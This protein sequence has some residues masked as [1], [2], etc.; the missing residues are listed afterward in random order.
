MKTDI[1]PSQS[2]VDPVE[3]TFAHVDARALGVACGTVLGA[4]IFI[5]TVVLVI[6]GGSPVGP[7]LS[8]LGQYFVGYKVTWGGS[9]LGL[10]YG[11][12]LGFAGGYTTAA[13]RNILTTAYLFFFQKRVEDEID[14]LP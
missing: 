8:L 10:V 5:A 3:L 6:R 2:R 14:E 12:V 1:Q 4:S 9:L 7:N 11:F 13:I